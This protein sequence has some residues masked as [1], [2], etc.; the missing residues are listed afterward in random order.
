M[1]TYYTIKSN[2]N[3]LKRECNKQGRK[4]CVSTILDKDKEEYSDVLSTLNYDEHYFIVYQ[5]QGGTNKHGGKEGVV[6]ESEQPS[7]PIPC[8]SLFKGLYIDCD[9]N[10]RCCTYGHHDYQILGNIKDPMNIQSKEKYETQ[11]LAGQIPSICT[12]CLKFEKL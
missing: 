2:I 4:L 6:G 1:N 10:V 5:S 3:I 8:W 9:L 7:S 11:Q 12:E